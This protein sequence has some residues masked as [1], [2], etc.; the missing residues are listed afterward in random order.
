MVDDTGNRGFV[1]YMAQYQNQGYEDAK[2]CCFQ[3]SDC[4][5]WGRNLLS[6]DTTA[7][8]LQR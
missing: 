7:L 6:G 5:D 2:A 8:I 4:N 1:G 3:Y